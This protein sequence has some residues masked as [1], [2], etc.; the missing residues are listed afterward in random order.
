MHQMIWH[1]TAVHTPP[2]NTVVLG[3]WT[4]HQIGA[5]IRRKG[6]EWFKPDY[7]PSQKRTPP[8][9]WAD[10]PDPPARMDASCLNADLAAEARAGRR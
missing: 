5:V 3:W 4:P 8:L 9:Y 10:L 6:N 2:E 7:Y 1:E